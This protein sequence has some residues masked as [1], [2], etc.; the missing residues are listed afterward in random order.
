MLTT[1]KLSTIEFKRRSISSSY[2]VFWNSRTS[3]YKISVSKSSNTIDICTIVKIIIWVTNCDVT[4][5]WGII[6]STH[7]IDS[8]PIG[9]N[10]C[11]ISSLKEREVVHR[12]L[13]TSFDIEEFSD[14]LTSSGKWRCY[15]TYSRI[16]EVDDLSRFK[17]CIIFVDELNSR[18]CQSCNI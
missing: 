5:I 6:L 8:Q 16:R 15:S 3:I 11:F 17:W 12:F 13:L 2:S 10:G 1:I 14:I 7:I 9:W 4:S 18:V